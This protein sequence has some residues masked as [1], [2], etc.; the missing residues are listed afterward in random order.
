MELVVLGVI[1]WLGY[2]F[3]RGNT[4]RGAETVRAHVYLG[5][6]MAGVTTEEANR[7][8]LY[9]V[10]SGPTETILS[11]KDRLRMEYEG[12]Q[13]AMISDAYSKGM[14]PLL[15]LWYR[16][17]MIPVKANVWSAV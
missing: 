1:G 8:C 11:A 16:A 15:P 2:S 3:L 4:K 6:L 14:R 5:G 9:D 12:S 10:V 17:I 13:A 7:V